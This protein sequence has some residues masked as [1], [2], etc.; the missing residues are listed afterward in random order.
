MGTNDIM[1]L[2]RDFIFVHGFVSLVFV[3]YNQFSV[4]G[5]LLFILCQ[6][7][8]EG[9]IR[10]VSECFKVVNKVFSVIILFLDI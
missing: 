3:P 2:R 10:Y 1:M 7:L 9:L 5:G 4:K 8:A 6:G